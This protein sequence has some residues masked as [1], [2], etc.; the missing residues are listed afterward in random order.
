MQ[1]VLFL[2]TVIFTRLNELLLLFFSY[3]FLNGAV[4]KRLFA[5]LCWDDNLQQMPSWFKEQGPEHSQGPVVSM[6]E[7][8]GKYYNL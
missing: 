8:L 4:L 6:L 3:S 5:N 7:I 1:N 2:G